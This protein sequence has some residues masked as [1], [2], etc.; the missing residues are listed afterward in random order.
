MHYHVSAM[1]MYHKPFQGQVVL[2]V[3]AGEAMQ[4]H[5]SGE[6]AV[7]AQ[8]SPNRL[9]HLRLL[10]Q[11]LLQNQWDHGGATLQDS[12][13]TSQLYLHDDQQLR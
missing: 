11:L 5:T 6:A 12:P 10:Y 1:S 7:A 4:A 8:S 3:H 13:S 9:Q 2:P